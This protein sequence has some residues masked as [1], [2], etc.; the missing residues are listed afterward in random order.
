M[1]RAAEATQKKDGGSCRILA[2]RLTPRLWI[3]PGLLLDRPIV[4]PRWLPASV[5]PSTDETLVT[6]T[7]SSDS[8]SGAVF[9][10]LQVGN[11]VSPSSTIEFGFSSHGL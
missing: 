5:T 10:G 3:D 7:S 8:R 9:S 6:V 2:S 1:A 4:T 11:Q